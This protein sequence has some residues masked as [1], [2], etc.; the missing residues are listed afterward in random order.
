VPLP[1][2]DDDRVSIGDADYFVAE[3]GA[4]PPVAL[5]HGFPETHHC[6]RHVA[7]RLSAAYRVVVPDL[8]GYGASIAPPGGP[9]GEGY[10]K[11]EMGD[12]LVWLMSTLGHDRFAVV[13]HDRGARVAFRLALD[14]PDRVSHVA[15]LNV[16]PTIDQFDR[17]NARPSLGYWPWL[18]LAQPAPFPEL[19]LAADPAI[20]LNHVFD[21]W[22]DR[23]EAID[24]ASRETYRQ[25]M[26]PDTIA[27]MCAD[28]RASFHIDQ[29]HDLDDRA[30]G[31]RITVPVL[32]VI[33]Q[34]ETQLADAG[35]VWA[36]WTDHLTELTVPGGHFIPEEAADT[37]T[38]SLFEFLA[39]QPPPSRRGP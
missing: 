19:L 3:A 31:R 20:V 14:Q 27:A 25:A 13:G 2:F 26:T 29:Y 8:R 17:M 15:V 37:L 11:R 22:S 18:L 39:S 6:W 21:T 38:A 35:S 5:L 10:T 33:G 16:V 28:Y 4:G 9:K 34:A 12:D 36:A 23:P 24:D 7:P 30:A 32:M 1:G